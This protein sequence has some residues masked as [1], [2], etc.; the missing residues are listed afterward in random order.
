M[1]SALNRKVYF[2]LLS[3]SERK[4]AD[5]FNPF[6]PVDEQDDFQGWLCTGDETY[7]YILMVQD[8]RICIE[9]IDPS[10]FNSLP[11]KANGWQVYKL[12]AVKVS[13]GEG[14]LVVNG[15]EVP[16]NQGKRLVIIDKTGKVDRITLTGPPKK[17]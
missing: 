5:A 15:V 14:T 9:G 8:A 1:L 2:D 17:K 10:F 3:E 7:P 16:T 6:M 4:L 12:G 13:V 11:R